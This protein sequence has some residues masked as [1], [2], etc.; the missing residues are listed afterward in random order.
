MT[1]LT[2]L[3]YS[4]LEFY[5]GKT[6]KLFFKA[7][8]YIVYQRIL[9]DLLSNFVFSPSQPFILSRRY[10]SKQVIMWFLECFDVYGNSSDDGDFIEALGDPRYRNMAPA[11]MAALRRQGEA[12]DAFRKAKKEIEEREAPPTEKTTIPLLQPHCHLT[13]YTWGKFRKFVLEHSGWNV[14]RR[15]A[16]PEEKTA[17]GEKRRGKVYFVYLIYTAPTRKRSQPTPIADLSGMKRAAP[18]TLVAH[19][20][21]AKYTKGTT[22]TKQDG[23][24]EDSKMAAPRAKRAKLSDATNAH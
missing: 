2:T 19:T 9:F 16:T 15:A 6:K 13:T 14:K 4:I 5:D 1:P 23:V 18:V 7:R 8:D 21:A 20:A 24:Q 12:E 17:S 10:P 3:P 11:S 22:A